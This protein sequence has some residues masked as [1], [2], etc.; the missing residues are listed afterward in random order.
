MMTVY[1][2]YAGFT[3]HCTQLMHVTMVIRQAQRGLA[4]LFYTDDF[5]HPEIQS[6]WDDVIFLCCIFWVPFRCKL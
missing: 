4:Y 3:D 5:A 6:G 2:T 1:V